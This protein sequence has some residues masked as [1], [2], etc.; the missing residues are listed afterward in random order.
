MAPAYWAVHIEFT[1]LP[2]ENYQFPL[3][4]SHLFFAEKVNS[5]SSLSFKRKGNG[6]GKI[7]VSVFI[8]MFKY[9]TDLR[10]FPRT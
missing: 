1:F 5:P 6:D 3:Y 8:F 2:I 7:E 9:F 10:G 4:P